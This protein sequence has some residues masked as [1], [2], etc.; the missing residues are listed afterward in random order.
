MRFTNNAFRALARYA[1]RHTNIRLVI[2]GSLNM[3]QEVLFKNLEVERIEFTS[4][5]LYARNITKLSPDL[6]I[7]IYQ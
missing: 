6:L 7:V 3:E 5:A 2:L 1:R 4:Y